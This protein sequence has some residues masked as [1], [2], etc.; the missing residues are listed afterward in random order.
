MK[1]KIAMLAALLTAA[2]ALPSLAGAPEKP[3]GWLLLAQSDRKQPT[4]ELDDRQVPA[5]MTYCRGDYVWKCGRNGSWERTS[6]R[7]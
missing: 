5:G 7:C 3:A 4:C 2:L 1:S 6:K